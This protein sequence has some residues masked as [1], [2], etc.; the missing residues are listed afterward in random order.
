MTDTKPTIEIDHEYTNEIVCPHCGYEY[1]DSWEMQDG[2]R[3]CCECDKPFSVDRD[4]S[5][6]YSTRKET[7]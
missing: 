7:K 1:T 6:T 5:V 3:N 2:K 4:V